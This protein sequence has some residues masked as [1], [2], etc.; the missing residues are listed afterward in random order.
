MLVR[1]TH[2]LIVD[3]D[4]PTC[5]CSLYFLGVFGSVSA[6]VAHVQQ[7]DWIIRGARAYF[8]TTPRKCKFCQWYAV[9]R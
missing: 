6:W 7:I 4:F 8:Y 9:F 2:V 3:A 5:V 1:C